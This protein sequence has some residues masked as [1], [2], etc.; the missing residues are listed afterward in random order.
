MGAKELAVGNATEE[1]VIGLRAAR[2]EDQSFLAEVYAS[3]RE[4][5][6][7]LVDWTEAEKAEFLRMQFEAQHRYYHEHYQHTSWDLI[8]REGEPIGRFY[9]ARWPDEVRIVDI[10]LLPA[11]RGR[12]IGSR[13][14][15]DLL[16]EADAA[17][18]PVS[19]HV[20]QF[21]PA[22]RLYERLGFAPVG[23]H[24]IYILMQRP[25]GTGSLA[26]VS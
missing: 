13:L 9:V 10:A 26:T 6:M 21:N 20:E 7:S 18:K 25:A 11:H 17:G 22:M 3:T 23:Q 2:P 24:G 19:I 5:E 8:L 15:L 16:R 4:L 12:G 1:P 14:I